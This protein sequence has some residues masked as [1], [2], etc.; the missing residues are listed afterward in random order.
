MVPCNSFGY[1]LREEVQTRDYGRLISQCKCIFISKVIGESAL[2]IFKYNFIFSLIHGT[3]VKIRLTAVIVSKA[4]RAKRRQTR[5][6]IMKIYTHTYNK[7]LLNN[8]KFV[9]LNIVLQYLWS[10]QVTVWASVETERPA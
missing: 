4:I 3:Q 1:R 6:K 10:F 5:L 9:T 2:R 7:D 8:K